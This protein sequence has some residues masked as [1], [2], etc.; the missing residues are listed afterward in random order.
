MGL[1]TRIK[2]NTI[3]SYK[4]RSVPY[5]GRIIE[6]NRQRP[7][8]RVERPTNLS[9]ARK[10]GYRAKQGVMIVRVRVRG[11]RSKRK[12]VSGGRKPSK[13]GRYF[14]RQVRTGDS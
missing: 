10:L 14:T 11:G 12:T 5:R 6:F 8:V 13:S 9:R 2:E 3:E 1:Y 7:I 4:N